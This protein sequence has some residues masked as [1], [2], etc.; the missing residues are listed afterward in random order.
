MSPRTPQEY[1]SV[2]FL[3]SPSQL[4]GRGR[5]DR[6][7]FSCHNAP[8]SLMFEQ[9]L[10]RNTPQIDRNTPQIDRSTPQIDR[11]H[12]SRSTFI[13]IY[14]SIYLFKK[15]EERRKE[16]LKTRDRNETGAQI[17]VTENETVLT[18]FSVTFGHTF[19]YKKQ[20]LG[21][22]RCPLTERQV[23]FP[24]TLFFIGEKSCRH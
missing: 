17:A 12:F 24:P 10:C 11:L 23:C 13:C 3:A 22:I 20:T 6:G 14:I 18:G 5:F 2:F 9:L 21:S 16:G 8:K 1:L 15:K 7:C 19:I 4:G